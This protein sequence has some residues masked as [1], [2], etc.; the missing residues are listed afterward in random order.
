MTK[1]QEIAELKKANPKLNRFEAGVEIELTGEE[2]DAHIEELWQVNKRAEALA[3][4]EEEKLAARAA[5]LKRLGI[6]EEEA[7]LLA[8]S[9]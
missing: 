8:Q 1:Q 9:L 7:A 3:K 2:Y 6:T 4:L 5:L